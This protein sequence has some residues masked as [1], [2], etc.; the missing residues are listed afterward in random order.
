[1][2]LGA[3]SYSSVLS[4]AVEFAW[5]NGV[6]LVASTGNDGIN[7]I[8]Y[9]AS[10]NEVVAV[11]ALGENNKI[12]YFSNYGSQQELA[13]PGVNILSTVNDSSYAIFDGTSM[14]SPQVCGVAA[15]IL[16]LYPT[17]TNQKL[18]AILDLGTVDLGLNG[19][20]YFYG[21]GLLN[22]Y[23]ALSIA[24]QIATEDKMFK[25]ISKT[26]SSTSIDLENLRNGVL[27]FDVQGRKINKIRSKGVY[28][29]KD[30]Q[31]ANKTQKIIYR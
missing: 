1:L 18:R 26:F 30:N 21:F 29:L 31:N 20:D 27:I 10:F 17:F 7:G 16:S 15:L 9:P 25:T 4:D 19:R 2:S 3:D 8:Y 11:G 5:R 23:R 22:A 6:L 13:C 24:Q 28:F 12:A 14:A